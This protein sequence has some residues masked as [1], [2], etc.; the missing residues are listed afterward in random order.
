MIVSM[1]RSSLPLLLFGFAYTLIIPPVKGMKVSSAIVAGPIYI[2]TT[3]CKLHETRSSSSSVVLEVPKGA[4]VK[5]V[6][7]S[8]GSW[9]QIEYKNRTGFLQSSF[10]KYSSVNDE[11]EYDPIVNSSNLY[12]SK[13]TFNLKAQVNLHEHNASSSAVLLKMPAGANVKVIDSSNN[14]WW[15]VHYRGRTGYARSSDLN[16][17]NDVLV[18]RSVADKM[19]LVSKATSFRTGP[20]SKARVLLRFEPGD[21]VIVLDD[22]GEW[23]WK[24]SFDGKEGWVKRQ[25]LED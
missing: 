5:V 25:L 18:S 17:S 7:S 22:S 9:W 4:E 14:Q 24:V 21:Q 19:R 15:L 2:A 12:N 16:Y 23:W 13:P 3:A 11:M 6:N 8:Y 1:I 10:L 20:D